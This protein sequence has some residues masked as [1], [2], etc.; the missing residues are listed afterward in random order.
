MKTSVMDL[1]NDAT[2]INAGGLILLALVLKPIL[3][4]LYA[5]FFDPLRV[6]NGPEASVVFGVGRE[7]ARQLLREYGGVARL[8]GA[9]GVRFTSSTSPDLRLSN[10]LT[11][12]LT[13]SL[14]DFQSMDQRSRS[15]T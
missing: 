13:P 14:V 5:S 8:G 6:I 11:F 3:T 7:D 1:L 2:V 15:N 10:L 9:F 4:K 12:Q